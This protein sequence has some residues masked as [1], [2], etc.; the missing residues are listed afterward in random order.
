MKGIA[1]SA[2]DKLRII[3][4]PVRTLQLLR[5]SLQVV[6][7]GHLSQIGKDHPLLVII[8]AKNPIFV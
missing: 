7:T 2:A 5:L 3:L 6:K 4:L 8:F 1:F